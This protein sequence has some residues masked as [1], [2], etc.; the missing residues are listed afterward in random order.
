MTLRNI[1]IL[2]FLERVEEV[3]FDLHPEYISW[4]PNV[5]TEMIKERFQVLDTSPQNIKRVSE[6]SEMLLRYAYRYGLGVRDNF[7]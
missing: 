7:F 6:G 3:Y 2:R 5:T 1:S 4:H